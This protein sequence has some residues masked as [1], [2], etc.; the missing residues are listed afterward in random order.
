MFLPLSALIGTHLFSL[1]HK[2]GGSITVF[3]DLLFDWLG[4]DQTCKIVVHSTKAKKL[5]PNKLNR[6]SAAQRYFPL[7]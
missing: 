2:I 3:V 5:N 1:I 6:R 7:S 4:F